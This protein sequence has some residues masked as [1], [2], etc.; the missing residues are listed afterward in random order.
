MTDTKHGRARHHA[1]VAGV[2][3]V[4]ALLCV[5]ACKNDLGKIEAHV[6]AARCPDPKAVVITKDV[7]P[8]IEPLCLGRTSQI[9]L[10]MNITGTSHIGD[11]PIRPLRRR[12]LWRVSCFIE[13]CQVSQISLPLDE[14]APFTFTMFDIRGR[15]PKRRRVR[16]DVYALELSKGETLTADFQRGRLIYAESDD[17][18]DASGEA[19]C[20]SVSDIASDTRPEES[21][22]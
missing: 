19:A 16:A 22:Q 2:L 8:K 11:E 5:G 4:C 14:S 13:E 12:V 15:T 7:P 17:L 20:A 9:F 1:T 21:T 3:M 6:A 10:V 18:F